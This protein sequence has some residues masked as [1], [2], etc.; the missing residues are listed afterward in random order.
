MATSP[1]V[2]TGEQRE[3]M[4]LDRYCF[5]GKQPRNA[6][7]S[8]WL[9]VYFVFHCSIGKQAWKQTT[10]WQ[11]RKTYFSALQEKMAQSRRVTFVHL[12]MGMLCYLWCSNTPAW[13]LAAS[14]EIPRQV[15]RCQWQQDQ[16]LRLSVLSGPRWQE[17]SRTLASLQDCS[18]LWPSPSLGDFLW[19]CKSQNH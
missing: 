6:G 3:I 15:L 13:L 5:L 4:R 12:N 16:A 9:P 10:L 19:L 17:Q 14:P 7:C 18:S 1:E 8:S 11:R 2:T